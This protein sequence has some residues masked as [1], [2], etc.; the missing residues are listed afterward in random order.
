[1]SQNKATMKKQLSTHALINNMIMNK[2]LPLKTTRGHSKE[3]LAS[4]PSSMPSSTKAITNPSRNK[5]PLLNQS[6]TV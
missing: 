5:P 3:A 2:M 1:M 6:N 4:I